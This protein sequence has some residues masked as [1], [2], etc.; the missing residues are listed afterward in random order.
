MWP[1]M[2]N[3]K[4]EHGQHRGVGQAALAHGMEATVDNG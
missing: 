2:A 4:K 1:Y 3:R